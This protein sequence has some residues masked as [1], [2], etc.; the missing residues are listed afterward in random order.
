MPVSFCI[1]FYN[2]RHEEVQFIHLCRVIKSTGIIHF[3]I[4]VSWTICLPMES[5]IAG[6]MWMMKILLIGFFCTISLKGAGGAELVIQIPDNLNQDNSTYRLDYWPPHGSPAPNTTI[7]SRDIGHVIQFSRGLPGTKY[8]FWLYYS[9]STNKDWLTWTASIT[10]APDPPSNLTVNVK[11]GKSA[12]INFSPPTKGSFSSF[13]IKL[14]SLA[15]NKPTRT[16]NL[17]SASP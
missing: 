13:K 6:R 10:T 8:E 1:N 5:I 17:T 7:A 14:L 4:L 15:E 11:N 16:I 9:N 3:G 2:S 12:L